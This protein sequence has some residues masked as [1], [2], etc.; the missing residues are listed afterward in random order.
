MLPRDNPRSPERRAVDRIKRKASGMAAAATAEHVTLEDI[1]EWPSG[2]DP[3]VQP[4]RAPD[5]RCAEAEIKAY[6]D[7][8][9]WL[10]YT[11]GR[12]LSSHATRRLEE[13]AS[14]AA[15]GCNGDATL[16]DLGF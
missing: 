16:P 2:G 5:C 14:R 12:R 15:D 13:R 4:D 10:C 9:D 7:A 8:E 11:C 3:D 6:R 1:E